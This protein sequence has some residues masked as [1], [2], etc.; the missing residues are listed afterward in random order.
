MTGRLQAFQHTHTHTSLARLTRD[1]HTTEHRK[2]NTSE[3]KDFRLKYSNLIS[4]QYIHAD[5]IQIIGAFKLQIQVPTHG[6]VGT[7]TKLLYNNKL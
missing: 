1:N 5:V 6:Y 4:T 7:R 3:R 2:K